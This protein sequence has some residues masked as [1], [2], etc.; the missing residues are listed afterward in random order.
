MAAGK[1]SRMLNSSIGQWKM[2][3]PLDLQHPDKTVLD[4]ALGNALHACQKVILVAGFQAEQLLEKYADDSRMELVVNTEFAKGMAGS[5]QCG[6][7]AIEHDHCFISH[8]DMP[9]IAPEIYHHIWQ[10]WRQQQEQQQGQF[11]QQPATEV[12][13][14]QYQNRS[15]HPVLISR[16][17]FSAIAEMNITAEPPVEKIRPILQ[18]FPTAHLALEQIMPPSQAKGILLDI[19]TPDAYQAALQWYQQIHGTS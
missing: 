9:F 6:L 12:V 13:F 15:G 11:D 1:S 4:F 16:K 14:P 8:G 2:N 18:Q 17:L 19:D 3:L 7:N 10:F 5:I